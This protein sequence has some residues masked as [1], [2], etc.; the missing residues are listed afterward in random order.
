MTELEAYAQLT[1]ILGSI[2]ILPFIFRLF[3][4]L[5]QLFVIKFFPPKYITLELKKAS[6]EKVVQ[7]I[8]ADDAKKLIKFVNNKRARVL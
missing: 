4:V 5:G 8:P 6:G 7:K 3:Y 2:M 1:L